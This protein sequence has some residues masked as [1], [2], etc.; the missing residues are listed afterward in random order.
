MRTATASTIDDTTLRRVS[1][2]LAVAVAV[3]VVHYLDN[4]IN[5]A[6]YPLAESG[7]VPSRTLVAVSWFAF[8]AAALAGYRFLLSGRPRAA[9]LA[10]ALYAGSGLVGIG[11]YT[12]PGAL[13][14]PW[15]RQT[16]IVADILCGVLVLAVAYRL[17]R[18]GERA[19]HPA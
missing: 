17:S 15:W 18:A 10:L 12:T 7:P 8:T 2:L 14:M 13:D 6:D 3:S 5:Y 4:V 9:A 11:H 1:S 16:H 19:A